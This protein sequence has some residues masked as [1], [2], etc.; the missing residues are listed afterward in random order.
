MAPENQPW[1]NPRNS[2][3]SIRG[4]EQWLWI[5]TS[6]RSSA[7]PLANGLHRWNPVGFAPVTACATP[8]R[9]QFV[10]GGGASVDVC[11]DEAGNHH[12]RCSKLFSQD[13]RPSVVEKVASSRIERGRGGQGVNMWSLIA[14]RKQTERFVNVACI[15][16]GRFTNATAI[17]FALIPS[18]CNRDA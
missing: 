13:S 1:R 9:Q 16:L 11:Q 10:R 4:W 17:L 5:R 8:P 15:P 14:P 3:P 6:V 2:P 18:T 7:N 12:I